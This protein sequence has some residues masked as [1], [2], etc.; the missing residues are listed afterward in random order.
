MMLFLYPVCLF[1]VES[2]VEGTN[3]TVKFTIGQ[4][5][6][7][8]GNK[9]IKTD[10][11][12]YV[13]SLASG[14]GRTMVPVAFVAPALGTEAPVWQPEERVVKIRKGD[15]EIR[16]TID[17]KEML[18]NGKKVQMDVAAEIK[19]L[20]TGGGRTMLPI[21]F[22]ARALDVG[23][24][25][26]GATS[27]VSFF[28]YT[29]NYD[30]KGTY[31]PLAGAQTIEGNV[32]VKA[33]GIILQNLVVKGNLIISEEVGN[34]DVILNN[35]NAKGD[36]IVRGGG[37]DSIHIN[38]GQYSRVTIENVNHQVRVVAVNVNGMKVVVSEDA[39]TEGII[40]EG[41]ID[42]VLV[43]AKNAN[44][45]TQGETTIKEFVI[46][47][48]AGQSKINLA[49]GTVVDKMIL[50]SRASVTGAGKV[51]STE[52]NNKYIPVT[53]PPV[54]TGI[55]TIPAIPPVPSTI[56][57]ARVQAAR[58]LKQL[59]PAAVVR[60]EEV[61][62]VARAA[63]V[64]VPV[65]EAAVVTVIPQHRHGQKATLKLIQLSQLV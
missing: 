15:K 54:N 56:P 21:A 22:I 48:N 52:D 12:P 36:T 35:I 41:K 4:K 5:N 55:V 64:E 43:E 13:K 3:E 8:E 26:D 34:G 57:P 50:N 62:A 20:G 9:K 17:S 40:L 30:Q 60:G 25:W 24:A 59:I 29:K 49:A 1:A 14:G 28:G 10:V 6:Y 44:I 61:P 11:A 63:E 31:G 42:S 51:N 27:S 65:V 33:D 45:T 18:V 39:S 16:I 53:N 37:K 23:Y 2:Q 32:A 47:E 19:N 58:V 46:G 38:G 7:Y